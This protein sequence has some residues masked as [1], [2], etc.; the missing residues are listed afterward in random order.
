M[1]S[2]PKISPIKFINQ[3]TVQKIKNNSQL[4][5]SDTNNVFNYEWTEVVSP[6]SHKRLNSDKQNH[7]SKTIKTTT[8][9]LFSSHNKFSV[10][11]QNDDTDMETNE[12][13]ETISKSPPPIFIKTKVQ[14]YQQ[15]CEKIKNIIEPTDDFT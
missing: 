11:S 2:K 7:L 14:N 8:N 15:F 1:N 4:S 13:N 5:E 6:K 10:L 9:T 12:E 3:N